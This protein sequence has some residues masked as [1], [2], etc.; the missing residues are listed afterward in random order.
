VAIAWFT[1]P[2]DDGHAF[3]AFSQDGGRTFSAPVQVDDA[4]SLGR[5]NVEQLA[6]GSAVVGWIE[7][8]KKSASFKVRRVE[9]GGL[10]SAAVTVTD[11]G[12]TRN[13]SYPR[14]AR[15][16]HELIFAW[17]GSGEHLRVETAVARLP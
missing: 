5:V 2:R 17:P 15:R 3:V 6:D 7:F 16:G 1:A 9:R 11:L 4:G 12:E 8:A 10:R 14:L 13:S